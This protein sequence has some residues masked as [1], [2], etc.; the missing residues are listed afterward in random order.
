ML[1]APL[2]HPPNKKNKGYMLKTDTQPFSDVKQIIFFASKFDNLI[3]CFPRC[4]V[5]KFQCPKECC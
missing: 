2:H 3:R 4:I 1:I 5:K